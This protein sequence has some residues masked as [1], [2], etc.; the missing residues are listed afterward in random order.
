MSNHY[1]GLNLAFPHGDARLDFTDLY[2]FPKPGDSS[3]SILIMDVHP[4]FGLNPEGPTTT[5]P[6]ATNALYE[7]MID[8]NGDAV[9]DIAYSVRFAASEGGDQTATLRRIDGMRSDRTA[10]DGKVI[11]DGA[12]VST[13]HEPSVTN[14]RQLPLRRL[15]QRPVFFRHEGR[16]KQLAVHWSRLLHRQKRVFHR[17]GSA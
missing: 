16:S 3:K 11:V 5:E 7:L 10:D 6:F 14:A 15:A 13:G 12:P 17:A 1:S 2:V 4:S 9:A 8:A